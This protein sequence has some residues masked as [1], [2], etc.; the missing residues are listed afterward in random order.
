MSK[1]VIRKKDSIV[2][3][4]SCTSNRVMLNSL[5]LHCSVAEE[6]SQLIFS[7]ISLGYVVPSML[8]EIF[9]SE[10]CLIG[11]GF[12]EANGFSLDRI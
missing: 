3:W 9:R 5:L 11:S 2:H 4:G 10:L 12:L 6:V 8:L 7:S 1:N